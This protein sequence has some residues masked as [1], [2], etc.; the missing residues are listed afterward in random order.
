MHN[1]CVVRWG[2][3][4]EQTAAGGGAHTCGIDQ[5]FER[6]RDSMER[7]SPAV[8]LDFRFG[9]TSLRQRGVGRN[10]NEGIEFWIESFDP[11]QAFTS[12]FDW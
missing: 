12:Q 10:R 2:A 3:I 11:A 5:V 9:G 6:N 7:S 1:L 4:F 8:V